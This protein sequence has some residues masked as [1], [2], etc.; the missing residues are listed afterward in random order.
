MLFQLSAFEV[1]NA[2]PVYHKQNATEH[3]EPEAATI[4]AV[5]SKRSEVEFPPPE[6]PPNCTSWT[7]LE[8]HRISYQ[9]STFQNFAKRHSK[10]VSYTN[11]SIKNEA[12]YRPDCFEYSYIQLGCFHGYEKA[13]KEADEKNEAEDDSNKENRCRPK[14][15]T[16]CKAFM[17]ITVPYNSKTKQYDGFVLHN[18]NMVHNHKVTKEL[19][20]A[21]PRQRKFSET[22]VLKALAESNVNAR[23]LKE[24]IREDVPVLLK[25]IYNMDEKGI[26]KRVRALRKKWIVFPVCIAKHWILILGH[27]TNRKV[28]IYDS[29]GEGSCSHYEHVRELVCKG[30]RKR[31][32]V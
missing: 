28:Y 17:A 10:T 8:K 20:Y 19:Y 23:K 6:I 7:E 22:P 32:Q 21:Y 14:A 9:D 18:Y 3:M 31:L 27:R 25:D 12:R 2:T 24:I 30:I 16:G 29:L 1:A 11:A 15:F 26:E 4:E 13:C 5:L